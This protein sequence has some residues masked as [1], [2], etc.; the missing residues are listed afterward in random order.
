ME[1]SLYSSSWYQVADVRPCLRSHARIHRHHYRGDLWYVLQ[2]RNSGRYHRFTPGAYLV[3]SLMDGQR[4]VQEIWD[5]ACVR[6]GDDVLTQDE[7]T[8]LL[9]QLHRANVL[10]GDTPTNISELSERGT[11]ESNRKRLMSMINPL[12]LRIPLL[13]PDRF[14]TAAMPFFRPLFSWAG[15]LLLAL[16][17]GYAAVLAALNWSELT[18][19]ISDRVLATESLL[20][21]LIAY[22]L[23]KILHELGHGFAVKRWGEEVHEM[24]VMFLVFMP[25][26]YVDASSSAAFHDKH[27]RALVGAAGII[28]EA[29]LASLAMFVWVNAE[30]GLLR[31]FAFNVM[32]IGGISTLLFNGNP[33]L[34]FDGYYVF[35]DAIEIPNLGPRSNRYLGYLVQRYLFG[36][37]SLKSPASSGREAAWLFSYSIGSFCYRMVIMT[38]IVSFVANRFFLVGVL[39]ATW[40]VFLMIG[41]PL[42]KQVRHLVSSPALNRVRTRAYAVT[43][44]IAVTLATFLIFVPLPYTTVAE[45]IVWTQDES[46]IYAGA[47]GV[48]TEVLALPNSRVVAGEELLRLEDP[49]LDSRV[50]VLESQVRELEYRKD[51]RDVIDLAEAKIIEQRLEHAMADL[52]LARQ[53]QRDLLVRSTV[54]GQ[55][56]V[57]RAEDLPGRFLHKGEVIGYVARLDEPVIRV[58]IAEGSADLVRQRVSKVEIRFVDRMDKVYPAKISREIPTL[59]DTLPSLALSTVG[60]GDIVLDPSD[61]ERPRALENLMH[62]ELEPVISEPVEALGT[63]VYVR[64]GHGYEPLAF[65]IYRALRQIFLRRF[66]V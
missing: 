64:F 53:R 6:L 39:I 29:V 21:M 33:L 20:L 38:V 25:V 37:K 61:P 4:T 11:R 35:S 16:I 12:A 23:I 57:A 19:N 45:G 66:N 30:E 22:P 28:V 7:M 15:A 24:G 9:S 59:S 47:E 2:D 65:R 62:V 36:L 49:L 51:S 42:I 26:P 46:T 50:S 44:G 17:I 52:E 58:V 1:K 54:D 43:A 56:I 8:G 60:G 10:R 3:I 13:D 31:A 14:L 63:R 18:S 55:F 5:L 32:L 34:K 41:L 48:V 40:S 27:K